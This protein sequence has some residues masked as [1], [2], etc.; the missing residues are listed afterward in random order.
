LQDVVGYI[1]VSTPRQAQEGGSLE[2]QAY[3]LRGYCNDKKLNLLTI[4]EDD[5]SAAGAQGHLYRPGLKQ[6][7]RIAK[8]KNAAIL[9]PSVDRLARHPAVLEDIFE[10]NVSVI[11]IVERRRVGQPP[12]TAPTSSARRCSTRSIPA[13]QPGCAVDSC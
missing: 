8:E 5:C 12:W 13:P 9:V 7:L 6:A 10:S 4:E 3:I 11:S 1:R 2:E